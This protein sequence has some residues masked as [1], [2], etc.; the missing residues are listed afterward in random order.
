MILATIAI[1]IGFLLAGAVIAGAL[2]LLV[3]TIEKS[4]SWAVWQQHSP[5]DLHVMKFDKF[6]DA[7]FMFKA[8][9]TSGSWA[10]RLR[11]CVGLSLPLCS[12]RSNDGS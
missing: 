12:W 8:C 6:S 7:W 2:H 3:R 10:V 11:A 9:K 5:N 4:I 1:A